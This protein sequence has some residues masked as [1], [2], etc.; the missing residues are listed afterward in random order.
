[1]IGTYRANAKNPA[2]LKRLGE[3]K[4]SLEREG[5]QFSIAKTEDEIVLHA[6]G[7]AKRVK[8]PPARPRLAPPA[9]TLEQCERRA[10]EAEGARRRFLTALRDHLRQQW[11]DHKYLYT[12]EREPAYRARQQAIGHTVAAIIARHKKQRDPARFTPE[13][14]AILDTLLGKARRASQVPAHWESYLH[15]IVGAHAGGR[16]ER[17]PRHGAPVQPEE[18]FPAIRQTMIEHYQELMAETEH[19]AEMVRLAKENSTKNARRA[20]KKLASGL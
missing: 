13:D 5:L 16:W 12:R 6:W 10:R 15:Y 18:E 17:K 19:W 7:R 14:Y 20:P 3:I 8:R 1:M 2:A 9:P 11:Q 4:T